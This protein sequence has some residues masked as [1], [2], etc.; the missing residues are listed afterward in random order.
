LVTFCRVSSWNWT[1]VIRA[2]NRCLFPLIHLIG[3]LHFIFFLSFILCIHLFYQHTCLCTP[4]C[5]AHRSQKRASDSPRTRVRGA[6]IHY[7]VGARNGTWVLRKST[8]QLSH[9]TA[10]TPGKPLVFE[11]VEFTAFLPSHPLNNLPIWALVVFSVLNLLPSASVT[12]W[13]PPPIL[14]SF[15]GIRPD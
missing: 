6:V 15:L 12:L 3:P 14:S 13:Y 2:G 7:W 11:H 1:Q 4:V 8:L 9:W 5:S 10:I